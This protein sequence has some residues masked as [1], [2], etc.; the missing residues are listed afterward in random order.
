MFNFA[1]KVFDIKLYIYIYRIKTI[2]FYCHNKLLYGK[3][4]LYSHMKTYFYN[5]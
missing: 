2:Y 5:I 1:K 4:D 3:H